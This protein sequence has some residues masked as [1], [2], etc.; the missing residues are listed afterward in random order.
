MEK[1]VTGK[2]DIQVGDVLIVKGKTSTSKILSIAQKVLYWKNTSSHVLISFSDGFYIHSTGDKGVHL[3]SFKELLPEI[4]P[5]FKA[6]R[7]KNLTSDKVDNL[8]MSINY[9]LNQKYNKRFFTEQSGASFCSEL[10]AKT[11]HKAFIEIFGGKHSSFVT[12]ADFEREAD[13]NGDWLDITIPTIKKFVEFINVGKEYDLAYFHLKNILDT[14]KRLIVYR[15]QLH[16]MMT[17][18]DYFSEKMRNEYDRIQKVMAPKLRALN[19]DDIH[20][21]YYKS[22]IYKMK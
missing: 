9:Y 20:A 6:I 1:N 22:Y 16:Q 13:L 14:R 8:R 21:K 18:S 7:L 11:Y 2:F 17:N 4:E 15:N 5:N 19:W 10:V 12:P 3:I